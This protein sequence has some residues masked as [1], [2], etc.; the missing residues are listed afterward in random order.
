[1][2]EFHCGYLRKAVRSILG[3]SFPDWR[4]LIIVDGENY[5]K[6]EELL[7]EELKD[8]R[9]ETIRTSARQLA[10][11]LNAAM[12]RATTDF[13]AI[14]LGDDMWSSHAT[15]VLTDQLK[16][17]P[18][19][20]VFHSS[21]MFINENDEPIS[22]IYYS[23]ESFN[24]HDFTITS[25]VKHLLCWRK[26]K[27]LAIGG[28]DESIHYVGP[29]DYDFPWS[30]AEAHAVFGAVKECLYL[31]RDHRDSYRL[32]THVP[33]SQQIRE[34]KQIMRKHGATERDIRKKISAAKHSYLRQ[35]LY[36]WRLEKWIKEKLRYDA[37][38]GWRYTYR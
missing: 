21:R 22:S 4:L 11:K 6:V 32:T 37:R 19:V 15:Q 17:F 8:P 2:G 13:V 38:K 10:H 5:Q 14:L 3:Q 31:M 9:I 28:F 26:D 18:Q 16:R 33:R 7:A 36:R 27:A 35:C 12:E 30:M 29:D 23:R 24:V 20:D 34:T 1:V 25:P